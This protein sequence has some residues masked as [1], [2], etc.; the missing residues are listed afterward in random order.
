MAF[1]KLDWFKTAVLGSHD[2]NHG[3]RSVLMVLFSYSDGTGQNSRPGRQRIMDDACVSRSKLDGHLKKLLN[4]G[5]I[6][7]AEKGGNEV[8][9]GW[10]NVYRLGVPRR[11][12]EE[13]T[14]GTAEGTL[15][16]PQ[17]APSVNEGAPSRDTRGTLTVL[18]GAPSGVPH[19]VIDQGIHQ[20]IDCCTSNS[21]ELPARDNNIIELKDIP[22]DRYKHL[23]GWIQK[24]ATITEASKTKTISQE[25][26]F[27]QSLEAEDNVINFIEELFG[28]D[29]A[30]YFASE[31][32]IPAK[33][34]DRYQAGAWLKKF[35]HSCREHGRVCYPAG[36]EV[37]RELKVS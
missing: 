9:K 33:A 7:L 24:S 1:S 5:Y 29:Y 2:L 10:A 11:L 22:A 16:Y 31:W 20:V 37:P 12:M 19:Q 14:R 25:D 3:D 32:S 30:E 34:A 35:L 8:R 21:D 28:E 26:A 6:V 13:S 4:L 23:L 36:S 15:Q 27:D 18:E 17:G